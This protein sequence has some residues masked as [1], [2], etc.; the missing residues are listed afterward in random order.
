MN[1]KETAREEVFGDKV[2]V[3]D[4]LHRVAGDRGETELGTEELAVDAEGVAGE[5]T[6]TKGEGGDAAVGG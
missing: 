5:G 2:T 3:R 6:G 4:R 1:H